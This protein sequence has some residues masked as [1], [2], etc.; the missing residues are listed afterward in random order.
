MTSFSPARHPIATLHLCKQSTHKC[1][2]IHRKILFV[3]VLEI[4]RFP[5]SK[6]PTKIWHAVRKDFIKSDPSLWMRTVNGSLSM[7][8]FWWDFD[9]WEVVNQENMGCIFLH[10]MPSNSINDITSGQRAMHCTQRCLFLIQ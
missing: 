2:F 9:I 10:C 4:Y 7:S 1:F 5:N 6:L 8:N 3:N